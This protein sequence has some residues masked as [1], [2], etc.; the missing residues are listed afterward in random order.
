MEEKVQPKFVL[1]SPKFDK[2][3]G[4]SKANHLYLTP[5]GMTLLPRAKQPPPMY[6]AR[7]ST[8]PAKYLAQ[9]NVSYLIFNWQYYPLILSL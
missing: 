6:G 7:G 9:E 2:P 4:A 5:S 3:N 1:P 8:V